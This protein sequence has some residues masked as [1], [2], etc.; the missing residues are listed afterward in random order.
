MPKEDK[1]SLDSDQ[2]YSWGGSEGPGYPSAVPSTPPQE[3]INVSQLSPDAA[4]ERKVYSIL[5]P[6]ERKSAS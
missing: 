3:A 5:A 2:L 6:R 4:R 1:V